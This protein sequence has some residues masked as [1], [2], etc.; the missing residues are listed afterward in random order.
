[1]N[2]VKVL[3]RITALLLVFVICFSFASCTKAPAAPATTDAPTETATEAPTEAAAPEGAPELNDVSD[4]ITAWNGDFTFKVND[5]ELNNEALADLTKWKVK[6]LEIV[7]SKGTAMTVSYAG[8]AVKDVLKAAGYEDATKLT[9]I[10]DDG[11]EVEFTITDENAL[12]TLIAIEK[13]KELAS[14]GVFF[15]P[16]LEE[17]TS[18]Y[19]KNVIEIK[20]E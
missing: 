19:A 6:D 12:Y 15:A 11:Y 1:M 13:D 18:N 20:A 2:N 7:N 3:K 14:A 4:K 8:Y 16:C 5:K 10:C 9:L 17:T